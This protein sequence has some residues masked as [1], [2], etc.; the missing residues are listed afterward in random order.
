MVARHREGEVVTLLGVK[1]NLQWILE[2][3]SGIVLIILGLPF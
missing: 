3:Q 1:G 2:R